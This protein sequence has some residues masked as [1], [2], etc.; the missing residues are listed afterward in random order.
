MFAN[1]LTDIMQPAPPAQ[2]LWSGAYK[3]PWNDSAF[4]RRM[5]KEH[6]TQSHAMA[7]RKSGA[8]AQQAAWLMERFLAGRARKVLDLGCHPGSWM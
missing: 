6:L 8:I 3:I 4:S 5:L 1:K 2:S 7:S